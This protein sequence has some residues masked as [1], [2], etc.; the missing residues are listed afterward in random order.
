MNPDTSAPNNFQGRCKS[1]MNVIR[2]AFSFRSKNPPGKYFLHSSVEN[3]MNA[4]Q[5]NG[6]QSSGIEMTSM[7]K[8]RVDSLPSS[9][10][11]QSTD[12]SNLFVPAS[13]VAS[14]SASCSQPRVPCVY[15]D[16]FVAVLADGTI[17]IKHFYN[18]NTE[19]EFKFE[20]I[21]FGHVVSWQQFCDKIHFVCFR[22]ETAESSKRRRSWRSTTRQHTRAQTKLCARAGESAW[23]TSGGPATRTGTSETVPIGQ[24]NMYFSEWKASTSSP[25]WFSTTEAWSTPASQLSTSTLLPKASS[26]SVYQKMPHSKADCH[27]R[28]S[29]CWRFRTLTRMKTVSFAADSR[30]SFFKFV[31]NQRST[32]STFRAK[33]RFECCRGPSKAQDPSQQ[34][35]G[36]TE[37]RTVLQ[38][39]CRW[40]R[41]NL[42]A[43][44]TCW[45]SDPISLSYLL[46]SFFYVLLAWTFPMLTYLS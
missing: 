2:R 12:V 6:E 22:R 7:A 26:A 38:Q 46:T 1:V 4:A 20:D 43:E 5:E 11:D 34:V 29:A 18:F 35:K 36:W 15:E 44:K 17:F 31:L 32:E 24:Q 3:I 42:N 27:V 37:R 9:L 28:H 19:A 23:T 33:W 14:T 25:T 30:E 16:P 45:L 13:D 10:L 21:R 40:N 8:P 39:Q 41:S